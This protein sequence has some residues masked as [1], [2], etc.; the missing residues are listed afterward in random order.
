VLT[1]LAG[2]GYILQTLSVDVLP[3]L[4]R[5]RVT[6]ITE[7]PGMSPEEVETRVTIPLEN[8]LNGATDVLEVRSTSD[9]GLSIILVEFDWNQDI[10]RARQIVGERLVTAMDQ[11]PSAVQPQMAPIASLLGQIM[12]IGMWSQDGSTS[13]IEVRTQADWVV[14]Q[15]LRAIRGVAQVITMGGGRRQVQ[16]LID[17]HQMHVYDVSLAEIEQALIDSNLNVT[18]GFIND[19]A[20][21]LLVRG[22]GRVT[23]PSTLS[24]IVVK[25]RDRRPVLLGQVA[26]IVEGAEAKRGDSSI[27]GKEAVVLTIQK[28]PT[29]D[30]RQLTQQ[31][32]DA[33]DDLRPSLPPDV[34][35]RPTYQQR[36]FIDLGISNVLSSLLVG[37]ILVI[38][39]L[40]VFLMNIRTTLITV[41]AIPLSLIITALVFNRLGLSINVMS[42]GGWPLGWGCWWTTPLWEWRTSI[43]AGGSRPLIRPR[44]MRTRWFWL[45]PRKSC[46]RSSLALYWSSWSLLRC[47]YC[48]A[49]KAGCSL[50]WRSLTWFPLPLPPWSP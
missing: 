15:R 46:Q 14:G 12:L 22:L 38:V 32:L 29:A 8:S 27:N 10:F 24:K 19:G 17:P 45:R 43:A 47:C 26:Q 39:I 7:C 31:I 28:Q 25:P 1:L 21:E 34:V 37:S 36:E 5:P 13:P 2:S 11:L 42:L 35:I 48:Q 9:I 20:E 3:N 33:L 4:T 30:T 44:P 50:R 18:G 6:I 49:S 41:L 16:V 23:D 40:M